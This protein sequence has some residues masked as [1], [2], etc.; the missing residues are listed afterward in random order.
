MGVGEVE[1]LLR[2]EERR[3]KKRKARL[4]KRTERKEKAQRLWRSASETL[5]LGPRR[6]EQQLNNRLAARRANASTA[7]QDSS[8]STSD[9]ET[10]HSYPPGGASSLPPSSLTTSNTATP[11]ATWYARIRETPPLRTVRSFLSMLRHAH[12]TAAH[13]RAIEHVERR[14]QAYGS[15]T[16]N[17]RDTGTVV[18]WGLGSFGIRERERAGR[19]RAGEEWEDEMG[20]VGERERGRDDGDSEVHIQK[21]EPPKVSGWSM[22]WWGPLRRWRLQDSTAYN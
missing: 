2:R 7:A 3:E 5:H 1:E 12:I 15:E 21:P 22:W 20:I 18:G 10:A 17:A 13:R 8:S 6:D 11:P 19:E 14:Q 9:T 4:A 16:E